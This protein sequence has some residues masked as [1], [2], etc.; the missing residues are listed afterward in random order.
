MIILYR[1]FS[2][3]WRI[4]VADLLSDHWRHFETSSYWLWFSFSLE[5]SKDKDDSSNWI[6]STTNLNFLL[7][8]DKRCHQYRET[9]FACCSFNCRKST[10]VWKSYRST[11]RKSLFKL[12]KRMKPMRSFN[13]Q[14][15]LIQRVCWP[16]NEKAKGRCMF[17]CVESF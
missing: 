6:S 17:R 11:H 10:R 2:R 13:I 14:T 3:I 5:S 15:E 8:N 16:K 7:Q 12:N 1:I 4:E 9:G